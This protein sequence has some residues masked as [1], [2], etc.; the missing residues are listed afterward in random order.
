LRITAIEKLPAQHCPCLHNAIH[1]HIK[2]L[3]Y[4]AQAGDVVQHVTI[5]AAAAAAAAAG[6]E[7]PA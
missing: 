1:H 7:L 5:P 4:K 6:T 2:A 3:P